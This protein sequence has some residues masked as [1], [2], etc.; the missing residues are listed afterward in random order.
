MQGNKQM[1]PLIYLASPYSHKNVDVIERRVME[2]TIATAV[3][4]DRGHIVYSPIVHT[5][6]L[7]KWVTFSPVNHSMHEMSGWM[8][9]DFA[10]LAHCDEI[11]VLCLDGWQESSGVKAEIEHA[12]QLGKPVRYFDAFGEELQEMKAAAR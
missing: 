10:F 5:H 3:L 9:Y 11:W 8:A 4:I 1:K 12:H 6:P 7:S 2:A